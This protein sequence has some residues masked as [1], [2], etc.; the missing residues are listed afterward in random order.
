MHRLFNSEVQ[1]FDTVS[2]RLTFYV[3]KN[4]FQKS[5]HVKP[6]GEQ[7]C[8][9]LFVRVCMVGLIICIKNFEV[10]MILFFYSNT[11]Q[12]LNRVE[13]ADILYDVPIFFP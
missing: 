4:R 8:V 6:D 11:S 1:Q 7:R 9:S 5:P 12:L 10:C 2:Y 3:F 13:V